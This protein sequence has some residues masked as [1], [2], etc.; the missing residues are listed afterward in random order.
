MSNA[1]C[2]IGLH[3]FLCRTKIHQFCIR[4][5]L[6]EHVIDYRNI[7]KLRVQTYPPTNT[8]Q[9]ISCHKTH[10]NPNFGMKQ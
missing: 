5:D 2:N 1:Y 4:I 8:L 7:E 10:F 6:R 9:L 3:V